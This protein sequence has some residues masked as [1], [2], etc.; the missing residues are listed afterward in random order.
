MKRLIPGLL[1]L[2]CSYSMVAQSLNLRGQVLDKQTQEP[3]PFVNIKLNNFHYG[4][5]TNLDGR[6]ELKLT[7]ERFEGQDELRITAIGYKTQITRLAQLNPERYQTIYLEP[8]STRLDGVTI[9]S[10]RARRKENTQAKTLVM[11]ALD[12]IPHNRPKNHYMANAFYR[13]YCKE[14]DH[15]VRLIEAGLDIYQQ[16]KDKQFVQIPEQRLAFKVGQLRRSFDF[17]E[18]ARLEHT[19]FSLN[20]LIANDITAYEFHNP[21][22]RNLDNYQFRFADTTKL[23][24]RVI[25]VIDFETKEEKLNQLCYEGTLF[26]E[27]DH[28]A[29]LRADITERQIRSSK[30]DSINT[31]LRKQVFFERIGKAVYP[32]R[33]SSDLEAY[34]YSFDTL[35]GKIK[36][37]VSHEAHVELM[38]NAIH[39]DNRQEIEGAEPTRQMLRKI[40]YDSVFWKNYTVLKATP[41]E[42]EIIADLSAKLDLHKQFEAFNRLEEGAESVI[43][44]PE[45]QSILEQYEGTPVYAVLWAG[46]SLPNFYELVPSPTLRK[47]IKKGKVALILVSLDATDAEWEMNRDI[48]GF[49]QN[50]IMH[51]RLNFEFDSEITRKFF[52]SALPDYLLFDKLGALFDAEPPLPNATEVKNYYQ[53]L[54]NQKVQSAENR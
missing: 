19:H 49:N 17:T 38:N 1:F 20:F 36:D 21:L 45:F 3:V 44:T 18:S 24:G 48:N 2:L 42:E 6:F 9:K 46:W 34:H 52:D 31:R 41:L 37:K 27:K 40:N 12:N 32:S 5:S 39:P 28:L 23:D 29:F 35:S 4:T 13:H 43:K 10:A 25:F 30:L 11:D 54:V 7:P 51:H 16:R 14:D 26:I 50:G 33:L 47:L 22:R 53:E 15:Y 8:V